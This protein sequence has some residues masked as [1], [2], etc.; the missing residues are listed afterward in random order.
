MAGHRIQYDSH[1]YS[2][3]TIFSIQYYRPLVTYYLGHS[4]RCLCSTNCIHSLGEDNCSRMT[5]KW[6]GPG[7]LP[8]KLLYITASRSCPHARL[9]PQAIL[10]VASV[11]RTVFTAVHRG[12]HGIPKVCREITAMSRQYCQR[13]MYIIVAVAR[14]ELTTYLSRS[15]QERCVHIGN[16][17]IGSLSCGS[18]SARNAVCPPTVTCAS[19]EQTAQGHTEKQRQL[20]ILCRSPTK[21]RT[22]DLR[23][24]QFLSPNAQNRKGIVTVDLCELG[25]SESN[26]IVLGLLQVASERQQIFCARCVA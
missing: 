8:S 3:C 5:Y 7:K 23:A 2:F 4:L 24:A 11:A 18:A 12:K 25:N 14:L 21:K 20:E 1:P 9:P 16:S 15:H 26:T 17:F 13:A 19:M 6:C 22:D 10:V